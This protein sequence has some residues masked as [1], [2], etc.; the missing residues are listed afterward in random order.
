MKNNELLL[1]G[2]DPY[3]SAT[4]WLR[5]GLGGSS[6]GYSR[7]SSASDQGDIEPHYLNGIDIFWLYSSNARTDFS[8]TESGDAPSQNVHGYSSISLTRLDTNKT[9][10]VTPMTGKGSFGFTSSDALLAQN[11]LGKTIPLIIIGNV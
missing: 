8:F 6:W 11:D 4:H 7:A 5:V 10:V 3:A 1:M 9:V 2:G